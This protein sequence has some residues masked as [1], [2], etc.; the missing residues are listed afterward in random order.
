MILGIISISLWVATIIGFIVRN[1]W[2]QTK[3]LEEMVNKQQ[4]FIEETKY[5]VDQVTKMFDTIDQE[6]IFRANDYVGQM[7]LDLKAL[8]EALKNYK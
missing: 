8:N 6:N 3:K 1:L 7:W 2:L 4:K 5:T